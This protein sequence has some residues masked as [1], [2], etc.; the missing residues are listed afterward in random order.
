[1]VAGKG[2]RAYG[3]FINVLTAEK[4]AVIS[5]HS[6]LSL[7]CK[8]R[9]LPCVRST[10]AGLTPP[11]T[12]QGGSDHSPFNSEGVVLTSK[13]VSHIADGVQAQVNL[14]KLDM[15][16]RQMKKKALPPAKA[17]GIQAA[18]LLAARSNVRDAKWD[19]AL[20]AKIGGLLMRL[21]I[22]SATMKV[23]SKAAPGLV[24]LEPAFEMKLIQDSAG[25][26]LGVIQW[27]PDVPKSL[28]DAVD[29]RSTVNPCHQPMVAPPRPWERHDRGGYYLQDSI[30]MRGAY[31]PLGPAK[32]QLEA[33]RQEHARGEKGIPGA[34]FFK[35]LEALNVLGSTKWRVNT[36]VLAVVEQVWAEGGGVAEVPSKQDLVAP[37]PPAPCFALHNTDRQLLCH[38]S[39]PTSLDNYEFRIRVRKAK[40]LNKD[41]H[42]MRADFLLKL[43]VAQ[44]NKDET[45]IYFPH[46]IDFRGR[47]YTMHPH[48]NHLGSD[49]CRGLLKFGQTKPLGDSG[50]RWLRIQVANVYG[51][52]VDKLPLDQR[53]QFAIDNMDLVSDS[54]TNPLRG[55]RWWLNAEDPWQCLAA[56]MELHRACQCPDPRTFESSLPVHQDGSCNGLQHYAALARDEEGGR[57]VNLLPG[58]APADVYKGIA[59]LVKE[60]VV[61][62]MSSSVPQVAA[63]AARLVEHVDRKLVKQTVMTSVY[64]V[65]F[66]GARDQIWNRLRERKAFGTE[67]EYVA[68]SM[69][70]ARKVIEA[71]GNMFGNAKA[72]MDWLNECAREIAHHE[73][74]V[75]WRTPVGLPVVQPY[76]K[77][78]AR[79]VHTVLQT[80]TVPSASDQSPVIKMKQ[81][82]AFPPNYI[83]S[84]D[85]AHMMLTACACSRNGKCM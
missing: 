9:V 45:A 63:D 83:H 44:K 80:F 24:E 37:R 68:M 61:R 18:N 11:D 34:G 6:V 10:S 54:A 5:L 85:A 22:E 84:L 23:P 8:V 32:A 62:D 57:A 43:S 67:S 46:N 56:C 76:R 36:D 33:L 65:T 31:G 39:K 1:M 25:R 48:L 52:G 12:T 55:K 19:P 72:V 71:L 7:L 16:M 30:I 35:L 13:V 70:A 21:V 17:L 75:R 28:K 77:H 2:V 79:S 64:G 58:D 59:I 69:Y 38:G 53:E 41:L 73:E 14:A 50:L 40:Q 47:A 26:Q 51:G 81:R 15:H 49:I 27:H 42:S 4:L 82:T 29:F 78:G 74:S 20:K 60:A 3:H 66:T